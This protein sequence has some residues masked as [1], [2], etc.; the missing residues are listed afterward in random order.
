MSMDRC[1]ICGD[2]F[3]TD[4]AMELDTFG[5]SVCGQCW[6][7]KAVECDVCGETAICKTTDCCGIETIACY[8]CL[9]KG[10]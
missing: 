4:F 9:S 3:D 7:K 10:E 2:I 8:E 1:N 6:D 5:K